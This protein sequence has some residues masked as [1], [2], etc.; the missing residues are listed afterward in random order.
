MP[1]KYF[2]GVDVGSLSTDFV[3]IDDNA[4]IQAQIIQATGVNGSLSAEQSR[5]EALNSLSL[6]E[7][8]LL[9]IIATGYGRAQVGF[10]TG[11]TTEISCHALGAHHLFPKTRTVIDIGGQD[12]KVIRIDEQGSMLDFSM[13][14]KCAAGTGR[15]LEVMAQ[16]LELGITELGAPERILGDAAQISSTC[17]VFAESEVISLMA[18]DTPRDAIVHGLQKSIVNRI[19]SMLMGVGIEEE[20]TLSGGVALNRGLVELL[21][22]KLGKPVNI[23][24]LPQ[25]VGAL[26]AALLARRHHHRAE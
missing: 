13:N 4:T 6:K 11:K 21:S 3:I 22:D 26:G 18:R 1:I 7:A 14:D 17:T 20:I 10:A 8:D 5:Q 2:A 23:P 19:I 24:D 25:T 12:S 15:F 16:R 9:G